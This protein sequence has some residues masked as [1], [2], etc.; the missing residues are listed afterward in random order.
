M[1][2]GSKKIGGTISSPTLSISLLKLLSFK[3]F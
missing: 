3:H 1:H 2:L